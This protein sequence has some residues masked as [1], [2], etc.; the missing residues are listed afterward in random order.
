MMMELHAIAT[1][2][3]GW[4]YPRDIARRYWGGSAHSPDP[5]AQSVA[6]AL[7]PSRETPHRPPPPGE[8]SVKPRNRAIYGLVARAIYSAIWILKNPAFAGLWRIPQ[9]RGF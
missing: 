9:N 8:A 2:L 3:Q 1:P 4:Q 5:T 6:A 7:R